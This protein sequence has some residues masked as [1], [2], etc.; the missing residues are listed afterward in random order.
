MTPNQVGGDEDLAQQWLHDCAM[1]LCAVAGAQ[2]S[3][4]T[5]VNATW[6]L[7]ARLVLAAERLVLALEWA[8]R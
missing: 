7:Q 8:N 6:Y 3:T 2:V 4:P 1:A 5:G